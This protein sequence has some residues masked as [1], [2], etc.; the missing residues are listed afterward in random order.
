MVMA[1]FLKQTVL[2]REM[3]KT[4][5]GIFEKIVEYEPHD[6]ANVNTV[7]LIWQLFSLILITKLFAFA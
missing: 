1:H 6:F 7:G 5:N 2:K 4:F 3:W